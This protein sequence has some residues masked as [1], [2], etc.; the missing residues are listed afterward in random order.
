[1]D[2][3]LRL[4]WQLPERG[5]AAILV[6][7]AEGDRIC[8]PDDVHATARHHGVDPTILPG[9]AHMMMLERKWEQPA[10]ALARWLETL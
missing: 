7:G 2:L 8:T 6:L 3:A 9:L 5:D 10:R 1:M 4:H